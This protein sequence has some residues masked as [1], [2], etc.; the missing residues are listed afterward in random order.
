MANNY[1]IITDSTTDMTAEMVK[2]LGVRV[3]P[4]G[5]NVAGRSCKDDPLGPTM[6]CPQFYDLLRE[7][8]QSVTSQI[9]SAEFCDEIEKQTSLGRDVL[10]ISFSSALSGTYQSACIAVEEMKAKY[11]ERTIIA[12]DSL[13]ASLGEG[14]LVWYA[15]KKMLAGDSINEVADWV[16]E[17]RRRLCHLFTVDDL[18]HLKRGGRVSGAAALIGSML[19]IKPLLHVDYNGRLIPTGKIRG[20]RQ[21]LDALVDRME[22]AFD[23]TVRQTVFISHG[24]ALE[25]AKYVAKKIRE[26]FSVDDIVI[27]FI[28]PVIGSHS[29]PGTVAVFFLG[30]DRI[31]EENKKIFDKSIFR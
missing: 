14:L 12:V 27:G 25:D 28:G 26:R 13:S 6:S 2:E 5:Y 30:D 19:G 23:P 1:V 9:N 10:I 4:L 15:A 3:I 18:K 29:G 17:N 31:K 20:R 8:E 24:D 16:T 11:P 7:G 21:S 22:S